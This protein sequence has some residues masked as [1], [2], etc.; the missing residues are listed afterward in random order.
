MLW[1]HRQGCLCQCP[2]EGGKC[3]H[4]HCKLIALLWS[5][6]TAQG[7]CVW[8]KPLCVNILQRINT[9]THRDV[10]L[11][12]CQKG[13][14]MSAWVAQN[15]QPL[16][17]NSSHIKGHAFQPQDH[18]E[19]LRE[20]AVPNTLT[21]TSCLHTYTNTENYYRFLKGCVAP[22]YAYT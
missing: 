17:V 11:N 16:H 4:T 1:F 14:W 18:E 2:P 9:H 8:A 19:P 5:C 3:Y 7:F 10:T 6:D 21:I 13:L 12:T 22:N 20:W 15:H